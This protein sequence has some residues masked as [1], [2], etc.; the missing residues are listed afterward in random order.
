MSSKRSIDLPKVGDDASV[1]ADAKA[2][3]KDDDRSK[4][5]QLTENNP[6]YAKDEAVKRLCSIGEAI[7]CVGCSEIGESGTKHIHAF[8]VY[9][10]AI[11]MSSLKKHF[12]RAHFEHCK[13]SIASN[14]DYVVKDDSEPYEVGECPLVAGGEKADVSAEVV[15]LIIKSGHSPIEILTEYPS[16]SDYVVRNFRNLNDI[17]E[18]ANGVVGLRRRR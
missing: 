13:G 18:S 11:K 15:A 1:I 8:V 16:Y 17:Y 6:D 3:R 12:P 2:K 4:K 7:Y 5:W 10:N 14:R 9:K